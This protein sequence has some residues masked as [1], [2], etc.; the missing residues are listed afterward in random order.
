MDDGGGDIPA[1]L[2]KDP[3][4]AAASASSTSANSY[5]KTIKMVPIVGKTYKFWFTY[6]YEDP[7]TKQ[8]TESA[9]S[10]IFSTSFTIPNETLPVEN[11]VLTS[12]IKSYGVKFDLNPASKHTDIIIFESLTGAFTGEEYIVYTGTSTSVTVQVDSFAPRWVKVTT[13]DKWMDINR[14]SVTAGPVNIL[15]N[16]P[17]TST[18]PKAPIGVSVS[19]AIDAEDKSGFS[20][21][22]DV[23]WTASTDSNTNGY[24]IRWSAND[25]STVLNPLWEYGQVDGRATN[26]FSITGLTPNTVYYW[27]VTA[28]SPFNAISWDKSVTGQVASGQ[29]GPISDPNAP[30]GN[31][32]LRS[33]ISIGGKLADLF[34][35][36]TGITQTINTSTTITPSQT[37]GTYN[38]IILD[39]STTNYGHNYWLNTGQFRVGSAS[40]FF[41]W[42]GSDVYTTGKI[43]A[44]GG[45]FTGDVRLNGGTLYTGPTPLTGARVR[46]DS[47]GLFGY[48]ATS[49]SNTTGQTFALTAADGKI[50]ARSGYIGGWTIQGTAQTLG[51]ISKNGTIL[52]SDG[53][54]VLGDTTGTLASIVKLSSTDPTYRIWVGSQLASNAKFKVG[55]DGVVYAN[56]AV[57]S[58]DASF[59]GTLTVGVKYSDGTT[60]EAV[61]TKANNSITSTDLQPLTT[62]VTNAESAITAKAS[63][64]SVTDLEVAV[65]LKASAQ[66]V[67]DL[68]SVVGLK[69][70]KAFV[71]DQLALKASLIA[72]DAKLN[73]NAYTILDVAAKINAIDTSV[74]TISGGK[75]TAGSVNAV[76]IATGAITAVKI[77][78]GTITADKIQVGTITADQIAAE[79]ITAFEIASGS[80]T[81]DKIVA[82]TITAAK[83]A[84]T[85]TFTGHTIVG[86]R[87]SSSS[88]STR[89]ELIDNT[90]DSLR[91]LISGTTVG[92]VFGYGTSATGGMVMMAGSTANADTTSGH[93]RVLPNYATLAGDSTTYVEANGNSNIVNVMG[94]SI[95]INAGASGVSFSSSLT[96]D[97]GDV[98]FPRTS[99]SVGSRATTTGAN[100]NA[101]LNTSTGLIARSTSSRRYKTNIEPISFSDNTIKSLVPVKFQGIGDLLRGDE[102]FFTGLIAEEVAVIPGL[103][104]LVNYNDDG[105]PEAVNYAALTV[106]LASVVSRILD[107]LDALEAK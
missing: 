78:A 15:A 16:D 98:Y 92:H 86:S 104:L 88:S 83:I 56:G 28:K 41:Y 46:F 99:T 94:T 38:G 103:E 47:A 5:T 31:I 80:I 52:G 76:Q 39:R 10:P 45:S 67:A 20:I 8:I 57:I 53:S 7:E 26:K 6:L 40:A 84:A 63:S 32:Q 73:E 81:A 3:V 106:V 70:A 12:G 105:Q 18:P 2:E 102:T 19:G 91:A 93:V 85:Q 23:S 60:L 37:L 50:D 51:T 22:M 24:V 64:Q 107:R 69:A 29:F 14:S 55:V 75:I 13:R 68:T 100:A 74:V 65:A 9:N 97:R 11:L 61:K 35:I 90:L 54:I 42:D 21:K 27:Q 17:D 49:T 30:A 72:L 34:K 89:V 66:T 95:Q 44:T 77:A 96:S 25:P 62:R 87:I 71:D 101:Y 33:I 48:D 1:D 79:T 43:N 59:S 4:A 36:G 82:G 58:G